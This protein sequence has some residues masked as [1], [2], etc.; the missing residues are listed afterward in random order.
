MPDPKLGPNLEGDMGH[1]KKLEN[2]IE[3]NSGA[4]EWA[5]RHECQFMLNKF[6][7]MGFTRKQEPDPMRM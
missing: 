1:S 7:L 3:H 2:V 4:L 6:G 5:K